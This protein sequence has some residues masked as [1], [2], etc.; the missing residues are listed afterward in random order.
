MGSVSS[1]Y[2]GSSLRPINR[3]AAVGVARKKR[4]MSS[5]RGVVI[6]TVEKVLVGMEPKANGNTSDVNSDLP[7]P[8]N[9]RHVDTS[10]VKVLHQDQL[11][12]TE[13]DFETNTTITK[14]DK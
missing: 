8:D 5:S 2:N 11:F 4:S 12:H 7:K 3:A 10:D 9:I 14:V 1:V 6:R 13:Y